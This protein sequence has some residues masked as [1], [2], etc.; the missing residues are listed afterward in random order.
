VCRGA[1]AGALGVLGVNRGA[2]AGAAGAAGAPGVGLGLLIVSAMLIP[3]AHSE[4]PNIM[5]PA[6]T[7]PMKY[8]RTGP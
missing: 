1:C 7:A 3:A 8:L 4:P 6:D 5:T 2:C